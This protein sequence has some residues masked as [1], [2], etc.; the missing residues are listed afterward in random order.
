MGLRLSLDGVDL[1]SWPGAPLAQAGW[2]RSR[3]IH[4]LDFT[5]HNQAK[6]ET[7]SG[8]VVDSGLAYGD[9]GL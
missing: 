9:M 4:R 5:K 1:V 3:L 6:L 7:Y 2:A 8:V